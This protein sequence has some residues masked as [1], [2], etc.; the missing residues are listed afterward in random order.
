[1]FRVIEVTIA[2][3]AVIIALVGLQTWKRQLHGQFDFDLALKL[4]IAVSRYRDEILYTRGS[5]STENQESFLR[6]FAVIKSELE[7]Q[8]LAAEIV[9]GTGANEA[10]QKLMKSGIIYWT[11]IRALNT[12]KREIPQPIPEHLL[13]KYVEL[14][15]IV[16]GYST[17]P[18][19]QELNAAVEQVFELVR[20]HLPQR[21]KR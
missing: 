15:Q 16:E 19:A 9:W 21:D 17:D 1:V 2:A 20:P 13:P 5:I 14:M 12:F 7:E 10:K 8:L 11:S 4:G 6:E 3:F 18:F